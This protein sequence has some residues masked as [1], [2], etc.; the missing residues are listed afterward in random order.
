MFTR[1]FI[2]AA[3]LGLLSTVAF[4]ASAATPSSQCK[5]IAYKASQV[6]PNYVDI[7]PRGDVIRKLVGANVYVPAQQG[8]SAEYLQSRVEAHM[9]AMKR[10]AM[11]S[12]PLSVEGA[13]VSVTSAG[14]GYWV[15][16]SSND[17]RS[18]EEI[19]RRA[20]QLVR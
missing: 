14:N 9:A 11:P 2:T 5:L 7:R 15:Q 12:C 19:L 6:Q 17:Q 3:A 18:A 13:K 20:Q 1:K 8:L 4:G 10:E 16:I